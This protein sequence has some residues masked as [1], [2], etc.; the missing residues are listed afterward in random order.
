MGTEKVK[1]KL[2]ED[3]WQRHARIIESLIRSAKKIEQE[4][5]FEVVE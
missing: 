3:V 4:G 2:K 5:L 1:L